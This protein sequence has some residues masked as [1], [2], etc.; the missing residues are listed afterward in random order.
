VRRAGDGALYFDLVTEDEQP[1]PTVRSLLA[2]AVQRGLP[3]NNRVQ[4]VGQEMFRSPA[5]SFFYE[6]G[7]RQQFALAG[8][9]PEEEEFAEILEFFGPAVAAARDEGNAVAV[10]DLSCGSGLWTRRLLRSGVFDTVFAG[11]Y[12]EVMLAETLNRLKA[13]DLSAAGPTAPIA[14]RLDAAALPFQSGGL[15]LIHAGAALHCW[16]NLDGSVAEVYRALATGGRFYATTFT[17]TAYGMSPRLTRGGR[18][19]YKFFE[20]VGELTDLMVAAGFKKE[21]VDVRI[22][23]AS[24]AVVKCVKS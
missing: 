16:P 5:L 15:D 20:G 1:P 18:T 3:F 14:V 22:V 11:D 9:R 6:R 2:G 21:D 17:T 7:W 19:G 24:C 13:D 10:L 8:F 23:G 4:A 12:S